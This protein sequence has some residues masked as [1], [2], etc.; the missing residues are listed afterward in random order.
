MAIVSVC[1]CLLLVVVSAR[2]GSQPASLATL[3]ESSETV[4]VAAAEALVDVWADSLELEN[5]DESESVD[6]LPEELD[7]PGWLLTAVS[8]NNAELLDSNG[9][10]RSHENT[11][12]F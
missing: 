5:E 10:V 1:C 9:G 6:S 3:A 8:L 4:D 11:E 2:F 7:V 12:L